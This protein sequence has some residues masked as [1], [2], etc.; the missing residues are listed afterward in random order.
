VE[1]Y[2]KE[3]GINVPPLVDFGP[4]CHFIDC[5]PVCWSEEIELYWGIVDEQG[6]FYS[7]RD[8]VSHGKR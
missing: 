4:W 2:E 6:D 5:P 1:E 8:G 3:C 7:L